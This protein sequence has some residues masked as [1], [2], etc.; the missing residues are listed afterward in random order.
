MVL[1]WT[2][3]LCKL[4]NKELKSTER[5]AVPNRIVLMAILQILKNL[6]ESRFDFV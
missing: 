4:I 3:H 6:K 1:A 2:V 5:C